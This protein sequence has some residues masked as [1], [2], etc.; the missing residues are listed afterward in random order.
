MEMF[1]ESSTNLDWNKLNKDCCYS[2]VL[3][4]P[5]NK[6]VARHNKPFLTHVLTRNMK[7]YTVDINDI[8]VPQPSTVSFKNKG[9]IW[10]SIKILP[11]YKEGYVVNYENN[12]VK[13]IN[14]KYQEV[15]DLRGNSNSLLFHY[16]WLKKQNKIK[17]FLSYYPE[18][19]ESFQY[20]EVCFNNLCLIVFNEYILTRVRKVIIPIQILPFL[21]PVL[22]KLHG[23]HL[24]TKVR[25]QL[26]DVI[27][28]LQNYP[29]HILRKLVDMTNNLSYSFV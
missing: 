25:I 10:K 19:S 16:F 14:L 27:N 1:N 11:Y 21:K 29:P 9:D 6:V 20:F 23:I 26:H 15:K 8:G 17:L 5:D 2:F 13:L 7:S 3:A 22:Y 12:F 24:K 18:S 4:H 28:N